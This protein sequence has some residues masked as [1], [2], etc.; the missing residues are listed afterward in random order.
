MN[1]SLLPSCRQ[2]QPHTLQLEQLSETAIKEFFIEVVDMMD[3]A[4]VPVKSRA[5]VALCNFLSKGKGREKINLDGLCTLLPK[6]LSFLP[7]DKSRTMSDDEV[8]LAGAP[9]QASIVT[10]RHYLFRRH[11]GNHLQPQQQHHHPP[12]MLRHGIFVWSCCFDIAK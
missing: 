8:Y 5:M 10:S 1:L 12:A 7:G 9:V 11:V 4:I 6:L 3:S 2:P